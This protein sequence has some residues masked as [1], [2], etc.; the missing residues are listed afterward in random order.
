[1][2][3]KLVVLTG[4]QKGRRIPL[5]P[6]VFVIGR[7]KKCH[8]RPHCPLVSR[9]H[10]AIARWAGKVVVR[11]LKSSN[12]TFINQQRVTGEAR[13]HDGDQLQVGSLQFSFAIKE[14]VEQSAPVQVVR[15]SDM[16]WLIES[17]EGSSILQPSD[18]HCASVESLFKDA[19]AAPT[20]PGPIPGNLSAGDYLREY[21]QQRATGRASAKTPTP[22]PS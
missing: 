4:K 22:T 5:P 16:Q 14:D 18:T 17:P 2:E 12:G 7:A 1:M 6:T 10:C 21:F 19:D 11:D 15:P 8:L 3:V 9:A 20:I 13:I